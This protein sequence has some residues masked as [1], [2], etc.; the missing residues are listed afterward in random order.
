M[1]T[2][3]QASNRQAQPGASLAGPVAIGGLML[4]LLLATLATYAAAHAGHRLAGL[5]APPEG[6]KPTIRGLL[7]GTVDWPVASTMVLV[8]MVAFPILLIGGIVVVWRRRRRAR[9]SRVDWTAR[10]MGRGAEIDGISEKA[11]AAT[12]RRIGVAS[13]TPGVLLG[14]TVAAPRQRVYG[15]WET[16]GVLFAGPRVGKTTSYATPM[17]LDAPGPVLVTSNKR[18]VVDQTRDP[19]AT[20]GSRVWVFDPQRVVRE[21]PTFWWDPLSYVRAGQGD[22]TCEVK[23]A[24]MAEHFAV[25]SA[26]DGAKTDAFFE[27]KAQALLAN[28]LLAAALEHRPIT[29]VH[30]WTGREEDRTA[31]DILTRAGYDMQAD[32]VAAAVASADKQR[33]GVYGTAEKMASCLTTRSLRPWITNDRTSR[34]HLDVGELIRDA[35]TLYSLSREGAGSSGTIVTCL[36]NAICDE[37]E[38]QGIAQGGRLTVPLVGVLDEAA[39]VCRWRDLPNLYSHYGSRGV[40]LMTILQSWPQGVQV[41]GKAGMEALWNAATVGIYAGNTKS[42]EFLDELSR[43]IGTYDRTTRS[44]SSRS[45]GVSGQNSV[46]TQIT[47]ES[48]M[49]VA[50]LAA[51]PKGRAI[52]LSSGNRPTLV[53]TLPWMSGPHRAAVEASIRAHDPAATETLHRAHTDLDDV[54]ATLGRLEQQQSR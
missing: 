29:D 27:P 19:R 39:N 41:W 3:E 31:V 54:Q 33:S 20:A 7:E 4:F 18:D 36:T 47:R 34:P 5:P 30:S 6:L 16:T 53:E 46:S 48:I 42:R 24:K 44:V 51:L 37:A 35:G 52:V 13:Q 11:A 32:V 10:V 28:L 45:G 2:G 8:A 25:N 12:A 9:R 49:D 22:D 14:A 21:E 17:I 40:I 23:A 43:L 50:D 38:E 15:D 26:A 1:N